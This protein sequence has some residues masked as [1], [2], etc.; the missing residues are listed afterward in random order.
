MLLLSDSRSDAPAGAVVQPLKVSIIVPAYKA[1]AT[2]EKTVAALA[3]QTF[4]QFEVIVVDDASP[5][6]TGDL[7][8]H[9]LRRF[10]LRHV[11]ARLPGNVGPSNA[12]NA[13]TALASGEYV[14]FQDADDTWMPDK[15]AQQVELMDRHP[16]V[17]LCGCQADL[18]A[19]DGSVTGPLFRNLP[20][21]QK[22]GWKLLL[23]N[24]FI[25]TSCVLVRRADLG[26][27][28]FD[29]TLRV[30]EDRDVWIKLASNGVTAVLQD[31]LVRN[32]ETPTSYMS[33]N[34]LLIASDTK[35]MVDF[36]VNAMRDLMTWRERR[37]IYGALHSS[38]G[39]G[40]AG[41]PGHYLKSIRHMLTAVGLGFN[42]FDNLRFLVL[43][44]PLI[45]KLRLL[46]GGRQA[47]PG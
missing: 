3:S 17:T 36:H 1:E 25:Q 19:A 29:P 10:G 14:A 40:L 44:N 39:K 12:R 9:A 45:L 33:S 20:S 5:D 22:A 43:S 46:S 38:I 8:C 35:R 42:V 4:T 26:T 18:V 28:P 16:E 13:G 30:A 7:A 11:V 47:K 6:N 34:T 32:L 23:S 15:L 2:I 24:A 41:H 31:V 21:F 27:H 37:V